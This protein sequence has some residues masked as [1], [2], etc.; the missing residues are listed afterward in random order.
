MVVWAG[1][2]FR[3]REKENCY[4]VKIRNGDILYLPKDYPYSIGSYV[5]NIANDKGVVENS[6]NDLVVGI[7]N[8]LFR[9][10]N[11]S[12]SAYIESLREYYD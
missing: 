6:Y 8:S 12:E 2:L 1:H 5:V 3:D 11:D 10:F 4:V 9:V 7:M